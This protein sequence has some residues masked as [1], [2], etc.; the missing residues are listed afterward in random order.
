MLGLEFC[1]G[2][3]PEAGLGAVHCPKTASA[4][5]KL[6]GAVAHYLRFQGSNA[7]IPMTRDRAWVNSAADALAPGNGFHSIP[8][9]LNGHDLNT[10]SHAKP[11]PAGRHRWPGSPTRR[12]SRPAWSSLTLRR[13]MEY[14]RVDDVPVVVN[15]EVEYQLVQAEP[16]AA[17]LQHGRQ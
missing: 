14:C 2:L 8:F 16:P 7:R 6:F 11:A 17:Y 3:A 13:G 5:S 1:R 9:H 12:C 15:M 4:A 10:R